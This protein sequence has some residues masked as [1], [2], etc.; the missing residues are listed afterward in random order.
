MTS[1]PPS[2]IGR[3]VVCCVSGSRSG[4]RPIDA[5]NA[6][7]SVRLLL[8]GN[9]LAIMDA[10]P[11][12]HQRNCGVSAA[13]HVETSAGGVCSARAPVVGVDQA[14][15][16]ALYCARCFPRTSFAA[17]PRNTPP[18][19]IIIMPPRT[20]KPEPH[21]SSPDVEKL[22][23]CGRRVRRYYTQRRQRSPCR[24]TDAFA[25]PAPWRACRRAKASCQPERRGAWETPLKTH[26]LLWLPRLVDGR[27]LLRGEV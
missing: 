26:L 27:L 19:M 21:M 6:M 25:S 9:A 17:F 5:E 23:R 7:L 15:M 10:P 1:L 3:S 2:L 12:H 13:R 24:E 14:E 8:F 22:L 4:G 11:A 20:N 16:A 18:S